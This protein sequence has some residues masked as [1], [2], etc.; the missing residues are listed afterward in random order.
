MDMI[1]AKNMEVPA[2]KFT[3]HF[4][5]MEELILSVTECAKCQ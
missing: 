2:F 1:G 4:E 3:R 5:M